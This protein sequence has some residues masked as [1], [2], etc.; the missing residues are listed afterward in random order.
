M[1]PETDT[2]MALFTPDLWRNVAIGFLVGAF[3]LGAANARSPADTA[4]AAPAPPTSQV[5]A[6][7]V[8][9]PAGDSL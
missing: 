1:Q 8:I 2:N 7:F 9:E 6:E 5:S 3:A 4:Q